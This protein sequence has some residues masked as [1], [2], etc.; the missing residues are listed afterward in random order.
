MT[1]FVTGAAGFIG[2][3]FVLDWFAQAQATERVVN[4]DKL[5]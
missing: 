3:N 2:A 5:T 1:I 4:I